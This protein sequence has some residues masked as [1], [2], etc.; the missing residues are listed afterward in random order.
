[1]AASCEKDDEIY[2]FVKG[3]DLFI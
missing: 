1:L 3:E 2:A